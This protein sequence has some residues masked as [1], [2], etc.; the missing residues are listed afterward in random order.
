[1][2]D[3]RHDADVPEGGASL[4]R[5]TASMLLLLFFTHK[6]CSGAL[7]RLLLRVV[8][9]SAA[10]EGLCGSRAVAS[11]RGLLFFQRA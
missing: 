8:R 7:V 11:G 4:V 9:W 5:P 3:A 2:S 10:F 6:L 1:M